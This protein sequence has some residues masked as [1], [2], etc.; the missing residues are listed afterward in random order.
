[1]NLCNRLDVQ[2]LL[3]RHGFRFS[4]SM[5]QNF[6]M[7]A[8]VPIRIAQ[9]AKLDSETGVLEIGPGIGALTVELAK[10]ANQVVAVELDRTLLPLL[11]ETLAPYPNIQVVNGNILHL[12]LKELVSS[13][14]PGL[15]PVVCA[16]LPYNITSPILSAL[17]D[18]KCFHRITV[19]VQK[20]VALRIC[21]QAGTSDYGAFSVYVQYYMQPE[22]LF[23]I[24]PGSFLQAPKVTSSVITMILRQTPIAHVKDEGFFFKVVKAAFGQ[25]RKT[26]LNALTSTFGNQLSKDQL[27]QI[28][29]SCEIPLDIRGERLDI[30]VFAA[31]ADKMQA[32]LTA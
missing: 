13:S 28:L 15:T 22:L 17:I 29:Q 26:L 6:L 11:K 24:P 19:M 2:A 32:A 9:A 18:S 3:S 4:K 12:N 5:G 30:P 23:D 31:L 27:R 14:F 21:A 25:R 20:E 10:H 7:D 1:M 16:N 8:S